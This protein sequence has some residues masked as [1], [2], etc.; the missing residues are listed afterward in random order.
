MIV[1]PI[2]FA[3]ALIFLVA[4]M[5]LVFGAAQYQ[6]RSLNQSGAFGSHTH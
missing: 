3:F 1:P 2:C 6:Q 4:I 5:S